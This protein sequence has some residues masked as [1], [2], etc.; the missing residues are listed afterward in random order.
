MRTGVLTVE[1]RLEQIV[2]LKNERARFGE[3]GNVARNVL[4]M[5]PDDAVPASRL[6]GG[7]TPDYE[8]CLFV[9][10]AVLSAR[11]RTLNVLER[12]DT[13]MEPSV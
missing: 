12:E 10:H 11:K 1:A 3:Q 2:K 13:L 7:G 8:A 6:G 9:V 4:E 5:S